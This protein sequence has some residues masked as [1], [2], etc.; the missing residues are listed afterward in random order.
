M[1]NGRIILF[2]AFV[3]LLALVQC[4]GAQPDRVEGETLVVA[5]IL[6][7]T[8]QRHDDALLARFRGALREALRAEGLKVSVPPMLQPAVEVRHG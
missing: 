4:S 6:D 2:C 3:L 8:G 7:E 5:P 1:G